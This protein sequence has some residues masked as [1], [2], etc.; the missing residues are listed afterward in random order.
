VNRW[1]PIA[2]IEFMA[3]GKIPQRVPGSGVG[4]EDELCGTLKKVPKLY[5]ERFAE[6]VGRTDAFCEAHLNG[7]YRALCRKMALA[8]CRK[9]LPLWQGKPAGWAA[10]II[11][12]LGRVNFLT[13]PSQRP[14]MKSEEIAQCSGVALATMQAKAKV[15]SE[16]LRLMALHPDWCISSMLED[17]PLVWF[18][19]VNGV[20]MDIRDAPRE[21]Q[22]VAYEQG[23]IPYIPADRPRPGSSND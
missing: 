21:A 8:A 1:A 22:V 23:L 5:A 7:D 16:G 13:D 9:G 10:G 4:D 11:Y 18:L 17:N 12:A 14:H 19:K 3:Q 20:L 6:I 15:I 2:R